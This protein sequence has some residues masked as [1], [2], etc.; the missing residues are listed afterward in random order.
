[1]ATEEE[2]TIRSD[3]VAA[4]FSQAK[5]AELLGVPQAKLSAWEL[6]KSSAPA[7][8]RTQIRELVEEG[9]AKLVADGRLPARK[10]YKEHG[11]GG[12]TG[13]VPPPVT[14]SSLV[15]WANDG[16]RE[17]TPYHRA[18]VS[19]LQRPGRSSL[20]G[21]ALFAG[22]GGMSLGMRAAGVDVL[23]FV[24]L[25][26]AAREVYG[27]N[28]PESRDLGRDVTSLVGTDLAGWPST[29][30]VLFGGPPCQGFS[31][32]GK[33]AVDDPRNSL[34]RAFAWLAGELKPA[35][36]LLENVRLM[37]SMQ[38][39]DGQ[40]MPAA[41]S[42][43]FAD[44]GYDG[45]WTTLDAAN[46]G[47]PQCRERFV[48]IGVREDLDWEVQWPRP[49]HSID[50]SLI[51]AKAVSFRDATADLS[52]LE[53]GERS[54]DP[55]HWAVKHPEHVI[56]WL[57][58]VPEGMSA[59]SNQDPSMRP[60]SG[61]NTTYQRLKW[62]EPCSTVGTNFGMISASRNVHPRD[63]RSL[64][65][66]EALRCQSFPDSFL[67]AGRWGEIRKMVGNAVPPLLARAL[68]ESLVCSQS[69]PGSVIEVASA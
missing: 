22:C 69:R 47:V 50:G 2:N 36:V 25:D 28:F 39:I 55:L 60:P 3:R 10:R 8:V 61:Y 37:T 53:S 13:H 45:A 27:L 33:R 46:Y 20:S 68:G 44:V 62:D 31:L 17:T 51:D 54:D 40:P 34:F 1:M 32:T 11:A 38:A 48:F 30:D 19:R 56:H 64:T 26:R 23:G 35:F 21:V 66:R 12:R 42:R 67:V 29:V 18:L 5:L 63:T 15:A 6:N 7:S 58:D 59:H 4:G 57:K 49:T 16:T 24:E 43:A 65:I 9:A 41:I 52:A 14:A